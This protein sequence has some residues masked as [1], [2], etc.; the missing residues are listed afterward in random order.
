MAFRGCGSFLEGLECKVGQGY[1]G[2][3]LNSH[4]LQSRS[5]SRRAMLALLDF[6]ILGCRL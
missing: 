6:S 3:N 4:V 2:N 5:R 1:G